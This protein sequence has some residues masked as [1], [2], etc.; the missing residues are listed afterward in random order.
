VIQPADADVERRVVVS[1]PGWKGRRGV[2]KRLDKSYVWVLL[3]DET[4]S[5][6]GRP[7]WRAII[8]NILKWEADAR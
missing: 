6:Y 5:Y 4:E 7:A 2:I 1:A 8:R 3:D